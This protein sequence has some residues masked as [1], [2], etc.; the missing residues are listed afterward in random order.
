MANQHALSLKARLLFDKRTQ[1]YSLQH[2]CVFMFS[3]ISLWTL[4]E[5]WIYQCRRRVFGKLQST[6]VAKLRH[7]PTYFV[8]NF[9]F[10]FT[11]FDLLLFC[12]IHHYTSSWGIRDNTF[13]MSLQWT[14]IGG[15]LY[16]E[17]AMVLLLMLPFISSTRYVRLD[18]SLRVIKIIDSMYVRWLVGEE[19]TMSNCYICLPRDCLV[20]LT[21]VAC[22]SLIVWKKIPCPI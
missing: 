8:W 19:N 3:I 21:K 10:S 13:N 2:W 1:L 9:L 12:A 11:D 18:L 4:H 6:D 22:Y 17:I 7:R 5:L 15:F 14:A 16:F 20:G